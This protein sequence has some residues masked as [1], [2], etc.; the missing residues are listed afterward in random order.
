M[1]RIQRNMTS[2]L[3]LS[4]CFNASAAL[5]DLT[6]Q[7]VWQD[8]RNYLGAFG[9][10]VEGTETVEGDTLT[11][12]DMA[13]TMAMPEDAGNITVTGPELSFV[14]N[15]DGTVTMTMPEVMSVLMK[16]EVPEAEDV[17]A[18]F[19]YV[20]KGV[21]IVASG[22]PDAITQ[23]YAGDELSMVLKELVAEGEAL[24]IGSATITM[25]QLGGTSETTVGDLRNITQAITTGPVTWA[26]DFTDP[27]TGGRFVIN[28]GSAATAFE[29]AGSYPLEIDFTDMAKLFGAGTGF[30]ASFRHEGTRN[31]IAIDDDSQTVQ[32]KTSSESGLFGVAM[33]AGRL[34]YDVSGNNVTF[35]MMGGDIPVPIELALVQSGFMF[36]M[37]VSKS[38]D[39]QDFAMRVNMGDFTVSDTLWGMIDPAG[40]L[41]RDPATILV[42][43]TGKAKLFFDFFDPEQ[44]ASVDN[45]EALP[46]ELNQLSVNALTVRA[47]GAELTG[48]GAFTFD[49]TN[50]EAFDGM[51]APDG[52]IDLQLSGAN[53]LIDK[54][55]GMGLLPEEQAMGARMMMGLFAVPGE[56]EDNLTSRIEVKPDG[57][58]LA[59]GQRLK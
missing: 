12:T 4:L 11:I 23:T 42:D 7:D 33:D 50:L 54:L 17:R 46:G 3:A 34:L 51:P 45:G 59:N 26:M 21:T 24:D 30:E 56:G 44:M 16:V 57:Q 35:E 49:N 37:P 27:E 25:T 53:A 52:A 28:G 32:I 10:T 13:M 20:S 8:W 48:G 1:T 58:I 38:D 15:G 29:G 5:A 2:A 41:P 22:T 9:Y 36:Q 18:A 31:D 40:Q 6:A 14:E 43:L 55:V 39:E 19:D 47:A